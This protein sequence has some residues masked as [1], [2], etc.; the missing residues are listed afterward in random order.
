M[1]THFHCH[2]RS[3]PASLCGKALLFSGLNWQEWWHGQLWHTFFEFKINQADINS[4]LGFIPSL[5]IK[6]KYPTYIKEF[7]LFGNMPYCRQNTPNIATILVV[8]VTHSTRN[9]SK[10]IKTQ[11]LQKLRSWNCVRGKKIKKI[12]IGG[13]TWKGKLRSLNCF[14]GTKI[15]KI[16]IGENLKVKSETEHV[17]DVGCKSTD[18]LTELQWLWESRQFSGPFLILKLML[19]T[20]HVT[21]RIS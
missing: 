17:V 20:F 14:R 15:K 3:S 4:L 11:I 8:T 21:M 6:E 19:S 2:Y 7:A 10:Q 1:L 18:Q 16:G 13:K 9:T 5:L 12:G